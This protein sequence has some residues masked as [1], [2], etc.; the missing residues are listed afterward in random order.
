[1]TPGKLIVQ[2]LIRSK[3]ISPDFIGCVSLHIGPGG[4]LCDIERHEKGLVR[5]LNNAP[6]VDDEKF[7][8]TFK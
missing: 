5:K 3:I 6:E 2:I 7:S 4:G 8:L 1:M